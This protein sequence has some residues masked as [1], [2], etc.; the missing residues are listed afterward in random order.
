MLVGTMQVELYLPGTLSLKGKRLI[1]KSIKARIRNK[2]NVCIAEVDHHDKW[3][4][5]TL[6]LS[7]VSNDK[8][9]L[10]KTLNNVLKFIEKD[11][12]I[13]VVDQLVEIL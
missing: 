9:F 13:E 7:C 1:L 5:A 11:D 6:G 2:F 10:E 4:R 8:R 12:R 3:Q